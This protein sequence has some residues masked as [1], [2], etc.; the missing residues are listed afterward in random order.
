MFQFSNIEN[1]YL[2]IYHTPIT[3]SGS[4]SVHVLSTLCL[5]VEPEMLVSKCESKKY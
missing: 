1:F 2:H 4:G 3:L 5:N